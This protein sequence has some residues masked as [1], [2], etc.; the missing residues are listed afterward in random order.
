MLSGGT[1]A[2]LTRT[3]VVRV[4]AL[5]GQLPP[6]P[7]ELAALLY[8][9]GGCVP[10]PR[11]DPRWAGHVVV[12]A[13]RQAGGAL[14]AHQH[15]RTTH[16]QSWTRAD[17]DPAH[18][19]HKVYVSPL[20]GDLA[21]TLRVVLSEAPQLGVPAWKVGADLAGLHRPDKIVLY[22]TDAAEADH[23][24]AALARSL[25]G[26]RPQGVP[27]TG[28]VGPTAL[29]SRGR[30]VAGTSWRAQVCRR[31]AEAVAASRATLGHK[32][33]AVEVSDHA[34]TL[35]ALGG[36]DVDTWHPTDVDRPVMAVV[37]HLAP[38]S[39]PR[40]AQSPARRPPARC[41]TR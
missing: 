19:V 10:D 18:L 17:A 27:F 9:A 35:V 7:L 30:D 6:A 14:T 40:P 8:R 31:V 29:V 16:W 2:E 33:T 5:T 23:V 32:A 4:S 21:A 36:L 28:Q 25:G 38:R 3:V 39:A 12:A 37:E 34:L 26:A 22:L 13:A 41:A 11:L 20:V 15:S 1:L 24:A